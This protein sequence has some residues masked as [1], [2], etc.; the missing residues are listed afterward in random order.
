MANP[1]KSDFS[2]GLGLLAAR[3]PLG[4]AFVLSSIEKFRLPG[5]VG[6]YVTETVSSVPQYV[7]ADVAEKFLTGVPYAQL[8]L[9]VL[10]FTGLLT[11]L[12]AFGALLLSIAFGMIHGFY[13]P[14][15]AGNAMDKISS[16]AIYAC[17]ALTAF[18]AGPGMFSVDRLL[19]GKSEH[20]DA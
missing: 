16:P 12:S 7:P 20:R 8:G 18:F 15:H 2:S 3:V 6:Q 5:G 17:F 9:G 10:V 19:F 13:D 11:R 14:S 1:F 4:V